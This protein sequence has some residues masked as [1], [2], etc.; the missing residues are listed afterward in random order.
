MHQINPLN[1]DEH[2]MLT[3]KT[4][5]LK[6]SLCDYS[7]AYIL[8]KGRVT[9]TGEGDEVAERQADERD[10]GVGFK[11]CA[12]FVNCICEINNTKVDNAKDIDIVMPMYNL[13][14]YSDNYAKTS[15]SLRQYYRDE[16]NYNLA[17]SESYKS[18][19]K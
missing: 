18:K 1:Q 10:K 3:A 17:D 8:V 16:V 12:P 14:E 5:I 13:I 4:T 7:D 6:S 11:N 9:I 2:T 15:G 19:K